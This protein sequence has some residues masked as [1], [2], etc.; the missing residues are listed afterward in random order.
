MPGIQGV[1]LATDASDVVAELRGSGLDFVA[2]YYRDPTSRWPALTAAEAQR[3]SALGLKIVAVW[4]FHSGKPWYFSFAS[5]YWEGVAAWREAAAIGQPTGSAIYFAVDFN[6]NGA[7]LY[8]VDQYFRGV[9]AAFANISRGRPGYRIG[10]YGSG[11]VCDAVTR[12]RLA[13]YSWLSNAR[14][15][16]G[17]GSYAGWNIRQHGPFGTLSF[18]HDSD[19]ARGDYGAF[20]LAGYAPPERLPP[21]PTPTPV[22]AIVPPQ[23]IPT[24]VAATRPEPEPVQSDMTL[25]TLIRSL[26]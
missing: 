7:D 14:A 20:A 4:E 2:R 22:A 21:Q 12:A 1:D 8:Q 25:D 9:N 13:Q 23:P 6:A 16:A 5:G 19:E 3:L 24:P 11:A 15:W 26:F 17:Y 18:N 10:V